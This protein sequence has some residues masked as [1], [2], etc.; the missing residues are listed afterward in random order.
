L[1]PAGIFEAESDQVVHLQLA[2]F[3]ERHR[4]AGFVALRGHRFLQ[5]SL[6]Q[7]KVV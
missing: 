4:R 5:A 6:R 3:V 1:V 7:K 2:H